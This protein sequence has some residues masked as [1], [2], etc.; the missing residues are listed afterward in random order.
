MITLTREEAQQ[1]LDA[2]KWFEQRFACTHLELIDT[3]R[4]RLSAPE[5]K[6]PLVED[7][8]PKL[9][10][11]AQ[12]EPEPVLWLDVERAEADPSLQPNDFISEVP[13]VGWAPLYLRYTAPPQREITDDEFMAEAKRRG[14]F[15]SDPPQ[16][17]WQGLTDEERESIAS[18]A[19][20]NP[21]TMTVYEYRVIIQKETEAK[22]KE[23][24]T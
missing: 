4:A 8:E 7:W 19:G 3:I 16:R 23:K 21:L 18:K 10:V 22:L 11:V 15:I 1:V 12:P 24:N 9:F 6:K 5:P 14:F 20:Y 13:I 17:E 2:L